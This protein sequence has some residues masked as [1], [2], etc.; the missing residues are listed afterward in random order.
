MMVTEQLSDEN[1]VLTVTIENSTD[2][3]IFRCVLDLRR[4]S[5]GCSPQTYLGPSISLNVFGEG[6]IY[7]IDVIYLS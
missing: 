5:D 3:R 6:Y 1:T 4:C 7:S 2:S